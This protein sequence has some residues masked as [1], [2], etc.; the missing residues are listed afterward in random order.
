MWKGKSCARGAAFIRCNE[1]MRQPFAGFAQAPRAWLPITGA[2]LHTGVPQAPWCPAP[3]IIQ[4]LCKSFSFQLS[5]PGSF[6][7]TMF[8]GKG[9][10]AHLSDV[11]EAAG[12]RMGQNQ[13]L[14][15]C[16]RFAGGS[17]GMIQGLASPTCIPRGEGAIPQTAYP[18]TPADRLVQTS[19]WL[20]Y[21]N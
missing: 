12:T 3:P 21:S 10:S 6:S 19:R 18:V 8:F 7:L 17:K 16:E 4:T 1:Q 11:T 15:G 14:L 20:L 13:S 5:S 9:S 2:S